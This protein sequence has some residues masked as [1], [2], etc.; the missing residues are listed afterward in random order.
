MHSAEDAA[1]DRPPV[2]RW[3]AILWPSFVFAGIA[4][5]VL[6]AFVDPLDLAAIGFPGREFGRELGYTI[7]FFMFWAVTAGSSTMTWLLLRPASAVNRAT[8][9]RGT[10]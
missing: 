4:T 10:R 3:G 2:R 1:F 5:M 8:S 7:G 6:F 9:T